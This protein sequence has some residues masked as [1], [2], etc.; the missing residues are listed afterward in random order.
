MEEPQ[1]KH[2]HSYTVQALKNDVFEDYLSLDPGSCSQ[3]LTRCL[4]NT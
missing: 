3:L 2:L 1:C 4:N